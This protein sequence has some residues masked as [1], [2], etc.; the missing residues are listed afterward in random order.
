VAGVWGELV[1]ALLISVAV[2]LLVLIIIDIVALS[3]PF[4]KP[5]FKQKSTFAQVSISR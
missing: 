4:Q 2:L 5:H 3:L 1:N